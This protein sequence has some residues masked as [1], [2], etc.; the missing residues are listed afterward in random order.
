MAEGWDLQAV[1]RG[2]SAAV[3][4]TTNTTNFNTNMINNNGSNMQPLG[5]PLY[6]FASLAVQTQEDPFC[7]PNLFEKRNNNPFEELE[8]IYNPFFTTNIA[9]QFTPAYSISDLGG[10]QDQQQLIQQQQLQQPQQPQPQQQQ[11][12][13]Q[14]QI[15]FQ[16]PRA[17]QT[18]GPPRPRRRKNQQARMVCQVTAACLSSDL[19]AW[20]K[21]GQKP[22]KGSP[23]PRNYYRCSS[24][25]GCGAR[26]QVERNAMDPN[27]FIVS[28][29][30]DHT[31]PRPTHRNSLAGSTR[32]KFTAPQISNSGDP[33]QLPI[34]KPFSL[35]LR[36]FRRQV[37]LQRPHSVLPWTTSSPHTS[38]RTKTQE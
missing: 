7:F 27:M 34:E 26:K 8:Q 14:Q 3:N 38:T 23:Y 28:Y 19:W 18:I 12:Q 10:F 33:Q 15:Q 4:N 35:L 29:T 24:S 22:I 16:K 36:Q 25:K 32:N 20:R 30:G 11:Q 17:A 6:E 5:D 21:Y 9:P 37:S 31:H 13:Q 2:C 1:V